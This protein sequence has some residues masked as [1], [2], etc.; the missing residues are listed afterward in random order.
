MDVR[1]ALGRA[2]EDLAVTH[3][4]AAGLR[5]VARNWRSRA[6]GGG[7]G[8]EVDIVG[9]DGPVLVF[10]EVKTRG[11]LRWGGPAEAVGWRKVV[12]YRRLAGA[13]LAEHPGGGAQVRFDVVSV[14]DRAGQLE[15]LEHLRGAF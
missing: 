15:V 3:L 7:P 1:A 10:V 8:S 2:G 14:L 11:S 6:V 5:V 12:R 13:W 9:W 4:E